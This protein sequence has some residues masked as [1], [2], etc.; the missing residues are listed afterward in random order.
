MIR[1]GTRGAGARAAWEE[2]AALARKDE[3]VLACVD[4]TP[5]RG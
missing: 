5:K 2:I 3:V 4:A 1:V